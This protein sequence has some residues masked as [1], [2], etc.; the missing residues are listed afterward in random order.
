[1]RPQHYQGTLDAF[2][3][4]AILYHPQKFFRG[5]SAANRVEREPLAEPHSLHGAANSAC[6]PT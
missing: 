3:R 6:E 4:E 5:S 1:M 2:P